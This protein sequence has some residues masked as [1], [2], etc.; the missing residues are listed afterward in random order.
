[1]RATCGNF[2]TNF[3][4]ISILVLN[5]VGFNFCGVQRFVDFVDLIHEKSHLV[6]LSK[7]KI[8]AQIYTINTNEFR[9]I[10][11]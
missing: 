11:L 6:S 4:T 1:M 8:T 7:G 3:T 9:R 5:F 2:K 10:T